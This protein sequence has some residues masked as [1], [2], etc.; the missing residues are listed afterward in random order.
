MQ[1]IHRYTILYLYRLYFLLHLKYVLGLNYNT[2]SK[3]SFAS[4]YF[5]YKIIQLKH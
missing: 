1:Y 3:L 4:R 2:S 5:Q